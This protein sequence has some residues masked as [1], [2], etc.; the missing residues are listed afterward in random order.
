MAHITKSGLN[1]KRVQW[2]RPNGKRRPG[3]IEATVTALV[4]SIEQRHGSLWFRLSKTAIIAA[5]PLIRAFDRIRL[6]RADGAESLLALAV[7]LMY[8]ADVRTG[9]I[10]KPSPSGG[11]WNRYT[12]ADLAQFAYG[13]QKTADIAR[14]KRSLKVM[15]ALGWVHPTR[16]VRHYACNESDTAVFSSEPA[17]R[18]LNLNKLCEMT[19]TAWLLKRDRKYADSLRRSGIVDAGNSP[20]LSQN[21]R[22]MILPTHIT[23]EKH[24]RPEATGDPPKRETSTHIGDILNLLYS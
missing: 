11:R 3:V 9:F 6:L 19:G 15:M 12:L 7:A 21:E 22:G 14:A 5:Y 20:P 4:K 13:G 16:Q 1:H 17:V 18:R 23:Q 2:R 8:L 10:G 24:Q